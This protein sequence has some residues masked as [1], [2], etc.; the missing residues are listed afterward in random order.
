M[1]SSLHFNKKAIMFF[2]CLSSLP[3]ASETSEGKHCLV[4]QMRAAWR[5]I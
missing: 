2:V 1:L 4:V 3:S 5:G